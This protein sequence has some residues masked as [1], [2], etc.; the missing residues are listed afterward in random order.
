MEILYRFNTDKCPICDKDIYKTKDDFAC[1]DI[2]CPMA[3]GNKAWVKQAEDYVNKRIV[4]S[5][6]QL[7][8]KRKL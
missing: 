7:L 3:I 2:D 8:E 5:I 6:E 1:T 4:E